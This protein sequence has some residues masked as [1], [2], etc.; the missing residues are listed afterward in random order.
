M[1]TFQM[2]KDATENTLESHRGENLHATQ[3]D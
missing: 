1:V 2:T 3:K